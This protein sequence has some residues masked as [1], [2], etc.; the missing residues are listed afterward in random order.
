M[1]K[2]R[3]VKQVVGHLANYIIQFIF[4]KWKIAKIM[5]KSIST[6][7]KDWD[8]Y[9]F[10]WG[11]K[12]INQVPGRRDADAE[13][14]LLGRRRR[15]AVRREAA[16]SGGGRRG[17]RR[18]LPRPGSPAGA[19][20]PPPAGSLRAGGGGGGG[21]GGGVAR[22]RPLPRARGAAA[23]AGAGRRARRPAPPV[24][25][26][27]K[28]SPTAGLDDAPGEL[29]KKNA[30]IF[31]EIIGN[32]RKRVSSSG[33]GLFRLSKPEFWFVILQLSKIRFWRRRPQCRSPPRRH[34]QLIR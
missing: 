8:G 32:S 20:V 2:Q 13:T 29:I 18:R 6:E 31:S 15:P 30:A 16:P 27:A 34:C 22:R 25:G 12:I 9:W 28:L 10:F 11:K 3:T 23:G 26:G 21:G 33:F 7:G 4:M 17:R 5:I 19:V 24:A 14:S 1:V